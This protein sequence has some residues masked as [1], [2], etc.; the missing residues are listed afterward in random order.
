MYG[1]GTKYMKIRYNI[2]C[3]E[4]QEATKISFFIIQSLYMLFL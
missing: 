1:I 4:I 3:S 2:S